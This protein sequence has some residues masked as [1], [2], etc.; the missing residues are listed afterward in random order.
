MEDCSKMDGSAKESAHVN[1]VPFQAADQ[2]KTFLNIRLIVFFLVRQALDE[3]SMK[4]S[5]RKLI[6]EHLPILGARIKV[7]KQTKRPEY[8]VPTA[9][10]DGHQSFDWSSA[11]VE[12]TVD[13]VL[14][15]LG[16]RTCRESIGIGP[17]IRQ[18][19]SQWAPRRWPVER[20]FEDPEAPILFVHLTHHT[21]G[22]VVGLNIPHSVCDM[23]GVGSL[24][25]AWMQVQAGKTPAPFIQLRPGELDAN[26]NLPKAELYRSG[27]YR[28]ASK[29][30]MMRMYSAL[31]PNHIMHPKE[32]RHVLYLPIQLIDSL[33]LRYDQELKKNY[34]P[35]VSPLSNGSI[36]SALCARVR[37]QRI[38]SDLENDDANRKQLTLLGRSKPVMTTLYE[39]VNGESNFP[40]AIGKQTDS[41]PARGRVPILPVGAPYLHNAISMALTRVSIPDTPLLEIAHTHRQNVL[42]ALEPQCIQR[43]LAVTCASGKSGRP[44]NVCERSDWLYYISNWTGAWRDVDFSAAGKDSSGE[45]K[46]SIPPP[47][48]LGHAVERGT[49]LRG[50]SFCVCAENQLT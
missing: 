15:G 31:M 34:G 32:A 40:G 41:V 30:D 27:K 22:T 12:S 49:P 25:R 50:E 28:I 45:S 48:V 24:V 6:R 13:E 42:A 7:N 20:K 43:D 35:D 14:D 17:D 26:M 18:V 8:H 37:E 38:V 10:Q 21:D 44:Y 5:L 46:C 39:T 16:S 23:F 33:R 1:I 47:I 3:S 19:E 11:S 4:T 29:R 9:F 2:L 36:I